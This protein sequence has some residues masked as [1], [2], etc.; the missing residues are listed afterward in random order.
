MSGDGS[1]LPVVQNLD[2]CLIGIPLPLDLGF[3]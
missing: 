2:F 3:D 1:Y